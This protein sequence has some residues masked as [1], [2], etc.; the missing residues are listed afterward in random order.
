[1]KRHKAEIVKFKPDVE[2]ILA[3]LCFAIADRES[4][5]EKPTQYELVKTLFLADR[6]HLNQFGRPVSFDNYVAMTHGPVATCAYDLLKGSVV[7]K[8][9]PASTYDLTKSS[10]FILREHGIHSF[11]WTVEPDRSDKLYFSNPDISMVGDILAESDKEAI[12]AANSVIRS[13]TFS[14][15]RKLTHDD[16]AYIDA[17]E[18]ENE[19]KQF[20]MSFG[21]FFEAPDF[22]KA[23]ELADITKL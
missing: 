20:P 22:K 1:M 12:K 5:G 19:R 11:P 15:I 16:P 9:M 6:S 10:I 8:D 23:R 7:Q 18:E 3:A 13:L 21:L 14:Q 17:W 2:R 4:H